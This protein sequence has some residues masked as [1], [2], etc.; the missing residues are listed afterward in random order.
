M[1]ED[2]Y[3]VVVLGAG[4]AGEVC[5]GR[6]AEAGHHVAIVEEHLVGG[7][8][9]FYACMPSKAL[10]R[11]AQALDEARRIPGA[12]QAATGTLDVPAALARR[13]EVVHD[14]DDSVQLPWLSERGIVL[15]RGRGRL[16]GPRRVRV[17]ERVLTAQR[18]V[19]VAT[20][21]GAAMPPID[22][23]RDARP[24]TN[25]EATTAKAAPRRLVVLGGGPVGCEM[26]QAW[27][28]LGSQVTLVEA[29]ERLLSRE[30][31]FAADAVEEALAACGVDVRTGRR[32]SAVTRDGDGPVTVTLDDGATVTGDE[33]LL[34]LGRRPRTQELGLE[35]VGLEPGGAIEVDQHLHVE[36]QPWLYAIG[37]VNGR[38]LLTH[39]GKYQGRIAADHICG[40]FNASLVYGGP[41]SPRVVFT[42]P[43][44]ASVGYT[45]RDA[46]EAGIDARAVDADVSSTAG[47]SFH[48]RGVPGRARLVVD[49]NRRVLVGA[50]FTGADVGD[51]LHAASIAIVGDVPMDRLWHAVPC[52]PTRSEV[53]LKLL[54]AYGL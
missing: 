36:S 16:D 26:A 33:L 15:V 40:R 41:L 14:L 49:E 54:E 31:P 30:E 7:E 13:D 29:A 8:C 50:T 1:A 35:T 45:L 19:V 17:G 34:A 52:F 37:D 51:F 25:R 27:T 43:Q 21:S 4:P 53:W 28:T 23:L 46:Q 38:A 42:E 48:G 20:G 12:A 39:Q 22:G 47:A 3:D 10:L 5:A 6:L 24:W 2:T 32:A 11:P 44:V 9:S 18:A